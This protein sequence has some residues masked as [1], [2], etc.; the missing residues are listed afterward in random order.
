MAKKGKTEHE[1]SYSPR[2]IVLAKVRG[3]PAWPGMVVD[4]DTVPPTVAKER[5][6]G[7]KSTF[8]CVRFFPAGDYAWIV[9]KDI[10]RLQKHEIEAY[11][12]EPH[13]KSGDLLIGYKTALNP[14]KWEEERENA[15]AEYEQ[16]EA[17]AE[18]DQLESEVGE[19]EDGEKKPKPK[20]RKREMETPAKSKAK[21]KA[22]KEPSE[23]PAKKKATGGR[24]KNGTKSNAMVESEDE[25]GADADAHASRGKEESAPPTKRSKREEDEA[26]S[27]LT[28]DPEATKVKDWRH[29]LQ[30]AFLNTKATPKPEEMPDLDKL[31]TTVETY[32][33][34]TLEYLQF[35]KI[36]KVMRHI[37]ALKTEQVPRDDEFKFRERAKVL[38]DKWHEILDAKKEKPAGPNGTTPAKKEEKEESEAPKAEAAKEEAKEEG[39][40]KMQVD[41]AEGPAP[42]AEPEAA[43]AVEEKANEMDVESTEKPKEEAPAEA[44]AGDVS[45]VTEQ[46]DVS[47]AE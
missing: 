20:K 2:D 15:R 21:S 38:V 41:T 45:A 39:S 40:E 47:M 13:K 27:A 9:P 43:P 8:Y 37:H 17:E 12:S 42:A 23:T 10:S 16:Y 44:A 14:E 22:K 46:G 36:G 30:K 11:I 26:D 3:Y 33:N 6:Q 7:K 24:K 4:P 5:P 29:K 32:D 31:F 1:Q 18:V 28:N 25:G 35:S 19:D 34:M